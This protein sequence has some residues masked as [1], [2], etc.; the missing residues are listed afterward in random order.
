MSVIEWVYF[1]PPLAI[2]RLGSSETPL[3]CFEWATD[4][5]I[6]GAHRTVIR[7]AVTLEVQ[8]DGS[9]R[10]YLP[11]TIRFRDNGRFRPAAPFFELWARV[12]GDDG[13]TT[14][15]PLDLELLRKVG[16]SPAN[17]EYWITVANRK[18][19][20]RTQKASCAFIA[21]LEVSA[22][23]HAKKPLLGVSPH[24]S[25][26]QPLV[27]RDRPIPLGHFQVIRPTEGHALGV[28]LSTLRVRFTP[29]KGEVYGPPTAISGPA[30]PVPPGAHLAAQ[31]LRGRIHEIVPE[32]NRILNPN[33]PWSS[34]VMDA[35]DQIDPQPSDSYDGVNVG[36]DV[37]WGVVDDTCDGIIQA[38]VVIDGVRHVASARILSSCPDFAP[39]RRHFYSLI[40]DL[41]DRDLP[42]LEI[43]DANI[44]AIEDEVV[45]LFRRVF[46]TVSLTSLDGTRAH[47]I[48]EDLSRPGAQN[49]PGLPKIDQAS[50]TREDVPFVDQI[51]DLLPGQPID[52]VSLS[53]PHDKLPYTS[54]A[55][56]VHAPLTDVDVLLDFLR[57]KR[58]HV[59]RLIRPPY[60]RFREL[61]EDPGP[62]PNAAF[63]D[64]RVLRDIMEDMRMPPYMRDSD[65]TPLSLTWRQHRLLTDFLEYLS[66]APDGPRRRRVRQL[67]ERLS[68]PTATA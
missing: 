18:A 60:G 17:V 59:E 45:D 4:V 20:R 52:Q 67:V 47:G 57:D 63:R 8:S 58:T 65:E 5:S 6:H 2:G 39:D 25:G 34:Y 55:R 29:A 21:H 16:G 36:D 40:D 49:F 26:E 62:E 32:K 30:S 56:F 44:E 13:C 24:N 54:V 22:T 28:D 15:Q 27:F 14:D 61:A 11:N 53:V 3:E 48:G 66:R 7:P 41:A 42:V 12:V 9:L 23:D 51:P 19:E 46:E 64:T 38:Q 1:R 10:P 50:M 68:R 43:N 37:S 33:T 31:T 35:P